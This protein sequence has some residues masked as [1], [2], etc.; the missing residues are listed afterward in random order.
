MSLFSPNETANF[1]TNEN[2]PT[3]GSRVCIYVVRVCT[4]I[5]NGVN[6]S[7]FSIC[8][9]LGGACTQKQYD[10]VTYRNAMSLFDI[11]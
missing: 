2:K 11:L 7:C 8:G 1:K 6:C 9:A 3:F 4:Y 5:H 10:L